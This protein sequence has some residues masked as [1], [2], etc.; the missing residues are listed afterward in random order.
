MYKQFPLSRK[1]VFAD[2]LC[3]HRCIQCY[4]TNAFL[5]EVFVRQNPN[6]AQG[7]GSFRCFST[8]V[9]PTPANAPGR[10]ACIRDNLQVRGVPPRASS[11]VLK[12]WRPGTETQYSAAWKCFCY[13]CDIGNPLQADLETVCD[14]LTEKFKDFN[15]SYSTINSYRSALSSMLLPV[16]GYSAGEHAIIACL[17][18]GMFHGRPP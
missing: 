13:W 3:L 11:Y 6:E 2:R 1:F 5:W 17:L 8:L 7:G 10:V 4:S 15:N 14:F 16:D 9:S 12:P 18:R